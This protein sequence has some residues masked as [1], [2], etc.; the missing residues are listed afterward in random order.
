[1]DANDESDTDTMVQ[2]IHEYRA[3][4]GNTWG[5]PPYTE[6]ELQIG[7]AAISK[8]H[9]ADCTQRCVHEGKVHSHTECT[10]KCGINLYTEWLHNPP[11]TSIQ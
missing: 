7:R 2:A 8:P 6:E 10:C 5:G 1:M 9:D 4:K 3:G 11:P